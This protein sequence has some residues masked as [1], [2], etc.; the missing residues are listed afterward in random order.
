MN[1]KSVV[2]TLPVLL[3]DEKKYS[4]LVDVLDQLE[5]WVREMYLRA[6]L[7][8]PSEEG[9]VPPGPPIAAPSRPDQPLS[10]VPPVTAADDALARV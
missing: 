3:K 8:A 4:D 1:F 9:R 7:C 10:H 2:V 6:G 5:A